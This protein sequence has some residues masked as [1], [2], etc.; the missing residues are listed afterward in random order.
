MELIRIAAD[1]DNIDLSPFTKVHG[2]YLVGGSDAANID[3][4]DS[5]TV[6]GTAKIT[7]KTPTVTSNSFCFEEGV[8]FRTGISVD[9]GGTAAVAYLLVS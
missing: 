7:L 5:L 8:L 9:I 3:V 4:Y 1:N 2:V 6:T